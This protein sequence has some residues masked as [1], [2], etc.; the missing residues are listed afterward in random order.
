MQLN[1][2]VVYENVVL[3]QNFNKRIILLIGLFI[4]CQ[5]NGCRNL[6]EDAN[7]NVNCFYD[8]SELKSQCLVRPPSSFNPA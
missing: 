5:E 3:R 1:V 2:I 8:S 4:Y 7:I 6:L